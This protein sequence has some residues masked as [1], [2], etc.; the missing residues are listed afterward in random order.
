MSKARRTSALIFA[1]TAASVA[2]GAEWTD[3]NGQP[4]RKYIKDLVRI[5]TWSHRNGTTEI[6]EA[7]IDHWALTFAAMKAEGV[8][9]TIPGGENPHENQDNADANRGQV[10]DMYREGDRLVGVLELIGSDGIVAASR[11]DVS[12]ATIPELKTGKG[13]VYKNAITHVALTPVP[14]VSGLGKFKIAASRGG[15]VSV[16]VLR[17]AQEYAMDWKKIAQACGLDPATLTDETAEDAIIKAVSGMTAS[18]KAAPKPEELKAAREELATLKL[19][20]KDAPEPDPVLVRLSAENREMKLSRL[21]SE[22]RITPA[23]KDAHAAIW[24]GAENAGLKLSL[25]TRGDGMFAA[26]IDALSKREPMKLG[27]KTGGQGTALARNV[28]GEGDGS[29]GQPNQATIDRSLAHLGI[30]KN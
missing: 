24:I 11:A 5:G 7:D 18:V 3:D 13:T 29:D 25:D 9:V 10:L 21:V 28:P 4:H 16:P 22:G 6:T 20:R 8:G 17:L 15:T 14:V 30:K 26:T 27:G 1:S 12:I 2:A 23:E 19:T